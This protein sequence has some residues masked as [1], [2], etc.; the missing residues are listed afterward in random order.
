MH[1]LGSKSTLSIVCTA[2]MSTFQKRFYPLFG[3][4]ASGKRVK[5]C[6]VSIFLFGLPFRY[7]FPNLAECVNFS[8]HRR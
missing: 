7:F 3:V 4:F 6:R 2:F 8:M 1:H 5:D